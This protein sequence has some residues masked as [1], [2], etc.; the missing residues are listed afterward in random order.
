MCGCNMNPGGP[1]APTA[2]P[3]VQKTGPSIDA[4]SIHAA[5]QSAMD[6]AVGAMEY[7]AGV[8]ES[9]KLCGPWK[10]VDG[11]TEAK[12]CC[13][14]PVKRGGI[15]ASVCLRV[16]RPIDPFAATGVNGGA[17]VP[18]WLDPTPG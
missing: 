14:P 6:K 13:T 3:A 18:P 15:G 10:P 11:L 7:A 9:R 17:Y 16:T 5:L 1:P 12:L 8:M 2:I 4:A